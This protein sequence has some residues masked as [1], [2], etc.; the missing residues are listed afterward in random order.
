MEY[1]A[2][3]TGVDAQFERILRGVNNSGLSKDTIVL[4]TSDHGNCL[5]SHDLPGKNNFFEEATSVPFI[6]RTPDI[7]PTL[8]HLMGF[9]DDIPKAVQGTSYADIFLGCGEK[10]KS[11]RP[12][13]QL[14]FKATPGNICLRTHEYKLIISKSKQLVLYNLKSDPYEM[15][16]IVKNNSDVVKRLINDELIPGLKLIS[17]KS[18]LNAVKKTIN[19]F[20]FYLN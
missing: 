17:G 20:S 11:S 19:D 15:Q 6:M 2:M 16:N 4:F 1:F 13:S 3:V 7:Y 18:I 5:G 10:N 8:L 9:K 14:L 12:Y